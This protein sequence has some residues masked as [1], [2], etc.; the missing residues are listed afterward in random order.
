MLFIIKKDSRPDYGKH[1]FQIHASR[2]MHYSL[3][4]IFIGLASAPAG[5][6]PQRSEGSSDRDPMV[7]PDLKPE[8]FRNFLYLFYGNPSETKFEKLMRGEEID[9]AWT[10]WK[11]YIDIAIISHYLGMNSTQ[12]W[13]LE[14]LKLMLD[15]RIFSFPS[16]TT[17]DLLDALRYVKLMDDDIL[18]N[19]IRSLLGIQ[20]LYTFSSRPDVLY[21][22]P[23]GH[24]PPSQ[25]NPNPPNSRSFVDTL[26]RGPTL[27]LGD[28]FLFGQILCIILQTGRRSPLWTKELTRDERATLAA[29][30]VGL[31]PLPKPLDC[32]WLNFF[33]QRDETS[34]VPCSDT[35]ETI[36]QLAKD[37]IFT[38]E[39]H[40]QFQLDSPLG[41]IDALCNLLIRRG[42]FFAITTKPR[43][44]TG[45]EG[46]HVICTKCRAHYLKKLDSEMNQ[47]FSKL[48]DLFEQVERDGYVGESFG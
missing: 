47:V 20:L 22:G 21:M 24:V 9:S 41:G 2:F 43:P 19:N 48:V 4:D 38:E 26:Y 8:Q 5:A 42:Y 13:A 45:L 39:A 7:L 27:R 30:Q 23:S 18:E 28:R 40:E 17:A 25:P 44:I 37:Y 33:T 35:C 1:D 10:T 29:V 16:D 32:S 12:T 11:Y 36:L 46:E 3:S 6:Y 31:T 14:R 34:N 15:H